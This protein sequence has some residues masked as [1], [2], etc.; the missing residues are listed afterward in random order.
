MSGGGHRLPSVVAFLA[1]GTRGDVQPLAVLAS[2]LAKR[3]G[4][5]VK[6][7]FITNC[8]FKSLVDAPL[9]S[10]GVC[11]VEYLSLPPATPAT[12]AT[13]LAENDDDDDRERLQSRRVSDEQHREVRT[14]PGLPTPNPFPQRGAHH[15]R[16]LRAN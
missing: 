7:H 4:G 13:S 1:V 12:T 8:K 15:T 9:T 6:V 3:G 5:D 2:N 10:A 16:L 14:R 11:S